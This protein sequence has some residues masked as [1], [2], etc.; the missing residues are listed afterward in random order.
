MAALARL[1]VDAEEDDLLL[2]CLEEADEADIEALYEDAKQNPM[3]ARELFPEG[4]ESVDQD[5]PAEDF[6]YVSY[7]N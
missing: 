6:W 3:I 5:V 7:T 2:W 4:V 1:G